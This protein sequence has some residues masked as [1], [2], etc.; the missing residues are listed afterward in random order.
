[1]YIEK[2]TDG[3]PEKKK[4]KGNSKA[5][6]NKG[7]ST[8]ASNIQEFMKLFTKFLEIKEDISGGQQK[9]RIYKSISDYMEIITEKY[10]KS[11]LFSKYTQDENNQIIEEIENYMLKKMHRQ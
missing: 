11:D 9:H 2:L 6:D 8:H 5:D 1:M 7:I 4:M 10:Q 3:K